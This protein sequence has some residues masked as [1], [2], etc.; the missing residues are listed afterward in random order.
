[1]FDAA[2]TGDFNIQAKDSGGNAALINLLHVAGK[3]TEV[4]DDTLHAAGAIRVMLPETI[5]ATTGYVYIPGTLF[6]ADAAGA[7]NGF[8]VVSGVPADSLPGLCIVENRNSAGTSIQQKITIIPGDTTVIANP[9]WCHSLRLYLNTTVTG[10]G[11]QGD[12]LDFPVNIR[13]N[14]SMFNFSEALPNGED[15]RLSKSNGEP[16][17]FEIEF[18]DSHTGNAELWVTIDTVFGNDKTHY[19]LL[20]WGNPAAAARSNGSAVFD[21]VRGFQGVW[22]LSA[23]EKDSAFDATANRYHGVPYLMK[24]NSG[25]AGIGRL[26]DGSGCIVMPQTETSKLSVSLNG[27]YTVSAWVY[28]D[29]PDTAFHVL[30]GKGSEQYSL[31]MRS[32]ESDSRW[33]LLALSDSA[34]PAWTSVACTAPVRTGQWNYI[35]GVRSGSGRYLYVN[36]TMVQSQESTADNPTPLPRNTGCDF[37]IGGFPPD[38][39]N[40][41]QGGG[42]FKGILDE[43]RF[44]SVA[45]SADWIRLCYANQEM[46][47]S[48]VV[49]GEQ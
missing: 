45:M 36:G 32:K 10:A 7:R 34:A 44:S 39:Q 35:V 8:V 1:V 20:Y 16:L 40:G 29:A 6:A 13:F 48:L 3:P 17:P 26:F 4:R 49:Y 2:D 30:A 28:V 31:I 42:F 33:E 23:A 27:F 47:D 18:W 22:H 46:V 9:M 14:K 15:I 41:M 43:V 25:T 37:S 21:T 38:I 5:D 11:V 24:A 19:M 12:V